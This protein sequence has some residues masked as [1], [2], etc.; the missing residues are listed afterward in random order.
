MNVYRIIFLF[1]IVLFLLEDKIRKSQKT[2]KVY[3]ILS[4]IILIL[5]VGLRGDIARDDIMYIEI[6]KRIPSIFNLGIECIKNERVEFGYIILNS[7]VKTFSENYNLLFLIVAIISFTNLYIFIN[8]FSSYY[9]YSLAFYYTRWMFLKE[10]T[11]IRSA[12]ACSFFYVGLIFLEKKKYYKYIIFV[13]IGSIFHKSILF[14]VSYPIF[15]YFVK[16][17]KIEKIIYGSILLLPMINTKEILNKILLNLKLVHPTYLIGYY[18]SRNSYIGVYY[19]ILFLILLVILNKKLKKI[20]KY[21]FLKELYIY[22]VFISSSLFYYGDIT[23]RLSSF[24]NV[25]FLLQD[26]MLK[27]FKNKL[28]IKFLM[29]IFLILL[30]KSNFTNRL[31]NEYLPYFK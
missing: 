24:F 22:S 12:L 10:F 8:Y 6:F 29:I 19:S 5:L 18:S 17:K 30:Y 28:L 26:K 14:C 9:F 3:K 16:N 31:E 2:Y 15:L 4:I 23:G 1:L 11:Q 20:K 7:I 25:E 27:I 13:I 21:N